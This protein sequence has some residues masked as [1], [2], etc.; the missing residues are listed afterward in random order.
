LKGSLDFY[1]SVPT[2]LTAS[3]RFP[4]SKPGNMLS[5]PA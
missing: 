2:G 3:I 1:P 5:R 4:L